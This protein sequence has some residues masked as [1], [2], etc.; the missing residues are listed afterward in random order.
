[1]TK[2]KDPLNDLGAMCRDDR[3][4]RE[5]LHAR[6]AIVVTRGRKAKHTVA[7]AVVRQ[8]QPTKARV[9][10]RTGKT[11]KRGWHQCKVCRGSGV[12]TVIATDQVCRCA[13]CAN[14]FIF[15]SPFNVRKK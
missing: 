8:E 4:P 13:A 3:C 6:H 15:V 11:A 5:D 12:V 7:E 10:R 2:K 14:G 1:M 9:G